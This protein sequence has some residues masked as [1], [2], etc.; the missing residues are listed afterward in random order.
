MNTKTNKKLCWNCEGS[1]EKDAVQCLYCGVTLTPSDEDNDSSSLNSASAI[2][3]PPYTAGDN[4]PQNGL[5]SSETKQIKNSSNIIGLTFTL[6][7][8]GIV[9]FLFSLM[10]LFFSNDGVL[11]LQW[12]SDYWF[13][14]LLISL[15]FLL[16]GWKLLRPVDE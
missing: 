2:P 4:A 7:L 5:Y 6:L 11:T 15:P 10:L 9:L 1:V 14:Y 13:I 8:S 16:L 12:D 3:H